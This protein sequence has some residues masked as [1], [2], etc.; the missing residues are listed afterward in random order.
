M[1]LWIDNTG[2][3]SAGCA[4]LQGARAE[5]DVRGL[6]QLA[7]LLVFGDEVL[8]SGFESDEVATR[9]VAIVDRL[10]SLGVPA[11]VLRASVETATSYQHACYDTAH[12]LSGRLAATFQPNEAG[13]IGLEPSDLPPRVAAAQPAFVRLSAQDI[14]AG[15]LSDAQAAAFEDKAAGAIQYLMAISPE[16]RAAVRSLS[17]RSGWQPIDSYQL[18]AYL[19]FHLNTSLAASRDA[20]YTPAI[21]RARLHRKRNASIVARLLDQVDEVVKKLSDTPLPA[22]A[23]AQA[24]VIKAKGHPERVIEQALYYRTRA[25]RLRTF[26]RKALEDVDPRSGEGSLKT[27]E[28]VRE[29]GNTLE[30]ELGLKPRL[31][32]AEALDVLFVLGLPIPELSGQKLV[33]WTNQQWHA[34]QAAVLTELAREYLGTL[35]PLEEYSV[36]VHNCYAASQH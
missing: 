11:S 6:L 18:N 22:P 5:L 7:T 31:A 12:R 10:Y 20:V 14:S 28:T 26:L 30:T 23:V 1:R 27:D 21:A 2:L 4:L 19:R 35:D 24:L 17:T 3:H 25:T 16:L 34:R 13:I 29:L 9:S 32:F 33:Q 15:E 36:L 8:F